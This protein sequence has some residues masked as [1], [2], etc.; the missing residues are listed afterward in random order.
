MRQ[1]RI[2]SLLVL[3][4]LATAA[5]SAAAPVLVNGGF[6]AG[7]AGW[8][9][10]DQAGGSGTWFIQTGTTSPVSGFAVPAPPEGTFAAMTDQTGPGSHVLYQDFVVPVG[11]TA[12]SLSFM[13]LVA[14]RHTMFHDAGNLDFTVSPNQHARVDIITTTAD[15]FSTAGG[16]VLLNVQT[17]L[18][19]ID[20]YALFSTDLTALLQAHEGET[21]RLRFAEVDNQFFI[22]FGIDDV[23]LDITAAVPEPSTLAIFGIAAVAFARRSLRRRSA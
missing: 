18:A 15:P 9:V 6:E 7:F 12:A 20:P 10:V 23:D 13:E 14:N 8:T 5:P 16:D 21:L 4:L 3:L 19:N 11:V 2:L 22:Q 1:A 17:L